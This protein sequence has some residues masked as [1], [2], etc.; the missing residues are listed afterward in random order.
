MRTIAIAITVLLAGP[1]H[2]ERRCGWYHNPTP[3]NVILEDADGRWWIARQGS[4]PVPGFDDAYT[5][6]FD[7]RVRYNTRGEII[8]SG[9]GY[10][11]S[12]ACADGAFDEG[13][14]A[15]EEV[16]SISR[17]TELPLSRCEADRNLPEAPSFG[18]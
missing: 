11:Y 17:L 3:G 15:Y 5:T 18:N 6:A 8:T 9:P 14:P 10:G 1:A 7:D 2:A 4:T 16:L 13:R 12:C